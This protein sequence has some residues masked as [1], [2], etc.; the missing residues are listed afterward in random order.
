MIIK[1]YS[2]QIILIALLSQLFSFTFVPK[3]QA[4]EITGP[5][6]DIIYGLSGSGSCTG[7]GYAGEGGSNNADWFAVGWQAW[8]LPDRYG[9]I[10][11][12][13]T[14]PGIT[15]TN[16]TSVGVSTLDQ[17]LDDGQTSG[18]SSNTGNDGSQGLSRWETNGSH[19]LLPVEETYFK[20]G[21]VNS[22]GNIIA[23]SAE[24]TI[25]ARSTSFSG[26]GLG[27]LPVFYPNSS[28]INPY[29]SGGLFNEIP[30]APTDLSAIL[31][32]SNIDIV[33]RFVDPEEV[34]SIEVSSDD[35]TTWLS[36]PF[37][38]TAR[39]SIIGKVSVDSESD[40]SPLVLGTNYTFKIRSK[41]GSIA[42]A[43]SSV[44]CV[45]YQGTSLSSCAPSGGSPGGGD[46]SGGSSGGGS[47][48]SS[49]TSTS[50][51]IQSVKLPITKLALSWNN[52]SAKPK[53]IKLEIPKKFRKSTLVLIYIDKKG[54][55]KV[56]GRANPKN[57]S[58]VT[59]SNKTRL[60]SG[61][62]LVIR[63]KGKTIFSAGV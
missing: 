25:P 6:V 28:Y 63:N 3:A 47:P 7:C 16:L 24:I 19:K 41:N 53:S 11:L 51:E 18:R 4:V 5:E 40:G 27:D 54:K 29:A 38:A 8:N 14:T 22:L 10:W 44:S 30:D 37:E 13:R 61:G 20:V 31:D 21:I 43:I 9:F 1:R 56:I 62:E 49:A 26:S 15:N 57:K 2:S 48:V 32:D 36:S 39:G 59:F 23:T 50:S 34:Q 55:E 35:G 33:T 45:K 42:G 17:N 46:S 58:G 12:R 52:Q 60:N